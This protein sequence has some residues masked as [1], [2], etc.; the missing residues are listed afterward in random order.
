[1]PLALSNLETAPQ[2]LPESS[3]LGA[4]LGEISLTHAEHMHSEANVCLWKSYL[5][6]DCVNTMIAMGWHLST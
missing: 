2:G 3:W 6:A 1:M 4:R 5:P